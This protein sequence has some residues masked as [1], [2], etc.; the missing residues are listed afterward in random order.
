MK[1][2]RIF[3]IWMTPLFLDSLKLLLHHPQLEWV[4]SAEKSSYSHI[5]IT[6]FNPDVIL[7]EGSEEEVT[8]H[9]VQIMQYQQGNIR[10]V[11]LNMLDNQAKLFEVER[12]SILHKNDL[13]KIILKE[14]EI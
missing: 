8:R 2:L 14:S 4:G 9:A 11:G 7:I 13:L 5:V 12:G 10:I 1:P 3:V 6:Q